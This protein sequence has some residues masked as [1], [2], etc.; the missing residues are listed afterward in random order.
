[1]E[2]YFST[3]RNGATIAV[4]S[5]YKNLS[6]HY[7]L[8]VVQESG[9]VYR[10]KSTHFSGLDELRIQLSSILLNQAASRPFTVK[11]DP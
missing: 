11:S 10:L 8:Y 9:I 6:N 4:S 7:I 2:I 1:M 3:R 5:L